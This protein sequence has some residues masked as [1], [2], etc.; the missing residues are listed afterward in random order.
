MKALLLAAAAIGLC[1]FAPRSGP[2]TVRL[3]NVAARVT[4]IPEA[5]RDVVVE[6]RRGASRLPAP[7]LRAD[8]DR[9]VISGRLPRGAFKDCLKLG[10]DASNG[11]V[12]LRGYKDVPVKALPQ[13]VLRTP[14]DVN[15]VAHGAVVGQIGRAKSVKLV[16]KRC[17]AWTVADVSGHLDLA[18]QGRG[19]VYTGSAGSAVVRLESFEAPQRHLVSL[20]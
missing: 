14:L 9:V 3:D 8:R 17:G 5:R 13:I 1:A 15:V 16:H 19:D 12:R 4:V 10:R 2:A 6:I 20:M 11:K 18:V 7:V